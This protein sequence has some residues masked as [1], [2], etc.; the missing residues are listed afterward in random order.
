MEVAPLDD[1]HTATCEA[2]DLPRTTPLQIFFG[3][4]VV[5]GG[6]TVKE[7]AWPP[8]WSAPGCGKDPGDLAVQRPGIACPRWRIKFIL[9]CQLLVLRTQLKYR[10][11][12]L[13]YS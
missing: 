7:C 10:S 8:D 13:V 2:L 12:A 3:G 11:R 9:V 1:I 6:C 4:E 5:L